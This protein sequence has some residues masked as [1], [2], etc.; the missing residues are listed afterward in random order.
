MSYL[1][2]SVPNQMLHQREL[3]YVKRVGKTIDQQVEHVIVPLCDKTYG[4]NDT[5]R[6]ESGMESCCHS[7]GLALKKGG[8]KKVG[9]TKRRR[10]STGVCVQ[11][12]GGHVARLIGRKER[13]NK[14]ST[15][16]GPRD[17]RVR[18]SAY[19]AIQFYDVQDRL[20]YDRPSKAVDWLIEKAKAAIASLED[21]PGQN[22][23]L[24]DPDNSVTQTEQGVSQKKIS[25]LQHCQGCNLEAQQPLNEITMSNEVIFSMAAGATSCSS[26][27]Q[28]PDFDLHQLSPIDFGEELN[29]PTNLSDLSTIVMDLNSCSFNG[30]EEFIFS[31]LPAILQQQPLLCENQFSAQR[32]PLQSRLSSGG[33]VGI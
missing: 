15:S 27:L 29:P 7:L 28:A 23:E 13:H 14:V 9:E 30:E 32:G 5:V 31:S 16:R 24:A 12:H 11:A 3:K 10:E 1:L 25:Q 8:K 20:G 6:A 21:L 26:Q 2:E 4:Y 22:Y 19:T 18:L 33:F 17:R